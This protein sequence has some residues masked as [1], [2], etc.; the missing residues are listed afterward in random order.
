[1]VRTTRGIGM[2]PYPTKDLIG[3]GYVH[4]GSVWKIV[5]VTKNIFG[6]FVSIRHRN[7][8]ESVLYNADMVVK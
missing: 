5:G 6:T 7:I 2:E 8:V 4:D 3:L 1:M